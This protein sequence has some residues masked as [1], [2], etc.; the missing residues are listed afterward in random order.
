[1]TFPIIMTI[2]G[3]RY[4]IS[5][6][7]L[8]EEGWEYYVTSILND[9]EENGIKLCIGQKREIRKIIKKYWRLAYGNK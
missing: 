7:G 8:I 5:E 9:L 6:Y 4:F 1:M 3:R 2:Y